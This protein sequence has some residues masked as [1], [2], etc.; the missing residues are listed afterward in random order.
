MKNKFIITLAAMA[1]AISLH[2]ATAIGVAGTPGV[3]SYAVNS[4]NG[5]TNSSTLATNGLYTAG[6]AASTTETNLISITPGNIVDGDLVLQL[7]ATGVTAASTNGSAVFVITGSVL[8][9]TITNNATTFVNQSSTV[10]GTFATVS[11]ALNGTATVTT[12]IVYSKSSTPAVANG[13]SL[14]L[15][16]VQNSSS[17]GALTNYSAVVVQ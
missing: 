17:S 14:Y 8:P 4:A 3:A 5:T 7:T 16:S 1:C 10:R 12:N 11:L 13:L 2:A 6:L 15:E 9:I